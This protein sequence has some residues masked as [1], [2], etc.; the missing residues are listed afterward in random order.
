MDEES[1]RRVILSCSL[2]L[3]SEISSS[4]RSIRR[5]LGA[6]ERRLECAEQRVDRGTAGMGH[7]RGGVTWG[8]GGSFLNSAPKNGS[9]HYLSMKG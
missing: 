2:T 8:C 5:A 4:Q 9:F 1:Q 7:G 6:Q 3:T